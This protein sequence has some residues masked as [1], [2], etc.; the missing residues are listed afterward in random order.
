[1]MMDS[2]GK[3]DGRLRGGDKDD[4]HLIK[5][6]S[7][8]ETITA[9]DEDGRIRVIVPVNEDEIPIPSLEPPPSGHKRSK[10]ASPIKLGATTQFEHVIMLLNGF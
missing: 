8:G 6:L 5:P 10:E 1:M 7:Q 9:T 4:S 3:P 2:P